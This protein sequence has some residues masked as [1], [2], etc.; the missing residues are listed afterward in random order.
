MASRR[1]V[2]SSSSVRPCVIPTPVLGDHRVHGVARP[3]GWTP[4]VRRPGLGDTGRRV[5]PDRP[6]DACRTADSGRPGRRPAPLAHARQ[7]LIHAP[8]DT[9]EVSPAMQVVFR[10]VYTAAADDVRADSAGVEVGQ[11]ANDLVRPERPAAPLPAQPASSSE[12]LGMNRHR[13]C[14]SGANVTLENVQCQLAT[15]ASGTDHWLRV[16]DLCRASSASRARL[17][18]AAPGTSLDGGSAGE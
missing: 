6:G 12:N 9:P 11:G 7:D 13:P 15:S 17:A 5:G 14:N 2:I 3:G 1:F 16:A 10:R 4:P 8:G 18:L